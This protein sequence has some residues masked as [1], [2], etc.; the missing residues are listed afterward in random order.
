MNKLIA[1]VLIIILHL[2]L[3]LFLPWWNFIPVVFIVV[4]FMKLPA[5][6]SWMIPSL[7][8]MLLWL[9]QILWLDFGTDFRSSQRIADIFG[10]PGFVSYLIP[11]LTCGIL[12]ALSGYLSNLIFYKKEVK[13]ITEFEDSMSIDEYKENT[14]GLEDKDLI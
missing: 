10:A 6:A 11:V 9:F 5:R 4:A 1:F 14:P 3:S 7:S 12:A 8:I 13:E 2:A